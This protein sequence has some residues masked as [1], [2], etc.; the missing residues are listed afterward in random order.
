[1]SYQLGITQSGLPSEQQSY[2]Q[3]DPASPL[4]IAGLSMAGS[5]SDGIGISKYSV[6]G[7]V[8][9]CGS[10]F[11]KC[12]VCISLVSKAVY[13]AQSSIYAPS[14]IIRVI[15]FGT[16]A[17]GAKKNISIR[18]VISKVFSKSVLA[19]GV[20]S[21]S[22]L[23][24]YFSKGL[25]QSQYDIVYRTQGILKAYKR[26]EIQIIGILHAVN[27]D[28]IT[29]W[30]HINGRYSKVIK[31]SG[32]IGLGAETIYKLVGVLQQKSVSLYKASG[33]MKTDLE[34]RFL[35][36]TGKIS[37]PQF[38]AAVPRRM[39]DWVTNKRWWR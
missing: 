36:I 15:S 30:G 10:W 26:I 2:I 29:M 28:R 37:V 25:L 6:R 12:T 24:R 3:K 31:I 20:L 19:K 14:M 1:M 8:M 35:K 33:E 17:S 21:R 9:Q 11:Y 16:V 34:T 5:W 32:V 27:I 7:R 39:Q 23:C 18:G 13:R 4:G 38:I 22:R